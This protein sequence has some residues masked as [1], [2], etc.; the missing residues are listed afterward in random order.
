GWRRSWSSFHTS[1]S[2]EG[3]WRINSLRPH[4]SSDGLV[5][6]F[7]VASVRVMSTC[8]T[9]SGSFVRV[10]HHER[11]SD[12]IRG[13]DPPDPSPDRRGLGRRRRSGPARRATGEAYQS[14]ERHL[15]E[16][17]AV[18]ENARGPASPASL[19]ARLHRLAV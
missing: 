1:H 3:T 6:G 16:P 4:T 15:R 14:R 13:A 18:A 11:R 19:H 5:A 2:R 9:A 10:P 17:H 12:A 7:S 8:L